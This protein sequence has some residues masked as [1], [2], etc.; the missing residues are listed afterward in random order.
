L[1]IEIS[2][3]SSQ[4]NIFFSAKDIYIYIYA[5]ASLKPSIISLIHIHLAVK[6]LKVTKGSM[7]AR[8]GFGVRIS[9]CAEKLT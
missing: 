7:E 9:F 6:F 8:T 3:F 5:Y 4:H 1:F 2:L